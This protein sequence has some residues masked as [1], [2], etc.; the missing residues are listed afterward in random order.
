MVVLGL[1]YSSQLSLWEEVAHQGV[2]LSLA[3]AL[4]AP[5]GME[6][7][8]VPNLPSFGSPHVFKP[9]QVARRGYLWWLYPGLGRLIATLNPQVIHV[10]SEPWGLLVAQ[11][12]RSGRKVVPHGAETLW[13]QG[14]RGERLMRAGTIRRN[15]KRVAG[16]A[17]WNKRGVDLART[18]GLPPLAPTLVMSPELPDPK[19]YEGAALAR[20][21]TRTERGPSSPFVIGFVGRLVP[22]KGVLD[23]LA[24]FSRI[25]DP[26]FRLVLF[27]RG[28]L[29]DSIGEW[30][31][32]DPRIELKGFVPLE[33]IPSTMAALDLLL[34]PSRTTS[35]S[36]EQ[37]GKVVVEAMMAGTP[38]I[39]SDAGSLPEV[40]DDAGL[41]V[42]EGDVEAIA[43]AI[44][45]VAMDADSW[46]ELSHRSRKRA[47]TVYSPQ[48]N[49]PK[50]IDFWERVI[51]TDIRGGHEA[52]P[53]SSS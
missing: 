7:A 51:S 22:E 42:P 18:W 35:G 36:A 2:D 17:S 13:E 44:R 4:Q 10:L 11:T 50:V 32:A 38:V 49:A 53:R 28:P 12:L 33:G 31:R 15:L 24:A 25:T 52:A 9:V 48:M 39:T 37:F 21:L 45:T 26:G 5:K 40:V 8:H 34:L 46:S 19:A 6:V 16:F 43:S 14:Q 23:L 29:E 47:L 30:S 20:L 27:G 1:P 41:I 3:L